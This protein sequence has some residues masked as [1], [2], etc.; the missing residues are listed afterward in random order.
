MIF[1]SDFNKKILD[2]L[3]GNEPPAQLGGGGKRGGRA[4]RAREQERVEE[5]GEQVQERGG[6]EQ[7]LQ[8]GGG[9]EAPAVGLPLLPRHLPPGPHGGGGGGGV[10]QVRLGGGVRGRRRVRLVHPAPTRDAC[11]LFLY[12]LSLSHFLT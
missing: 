10:P 4:W 6:A 9:G 2:V 7:V 5:G 8:Q 11:A 12:A 3:S 1:H